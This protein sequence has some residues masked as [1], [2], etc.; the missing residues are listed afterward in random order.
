MARVAMIEVIMIR[1]EL[2]VV[3]GDLQVVAGVRC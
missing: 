3:V 2:Q 1:G